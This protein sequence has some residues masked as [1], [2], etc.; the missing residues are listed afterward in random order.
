M[1]IIKAYNV[2]LGYVWNE[3]LAGKLFHQCT[4]RD[5][6]VTVVGRVSNVM[7]K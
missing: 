3:K 5:S 4:L 6:S 7:F 1:I 2:F